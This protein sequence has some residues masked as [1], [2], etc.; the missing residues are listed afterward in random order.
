MYEAGVEEVW[1]SQAFE[2][3]IFKNDEGGILHDRY[4]H[5]ADNILDQWSVYEKVNI[6]YLCRD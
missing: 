6:L 4:H 1:N 3:F 2:K 5:Q